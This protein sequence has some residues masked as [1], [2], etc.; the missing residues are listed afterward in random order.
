[1]VFRF[2]GKAYVV[3]TNQGSVKIVKKSKRT[4]LVKDMCTKIQTTTGICGKTDEVSNCAYSILS[5]RPSVSK[6]CLLTLNATVVSCSMQ[7]FYCFIFFI[8][9]FI[10][11]PDRIWENG[12]KTSGCQLSVPADFESF[13]KTYIDPLTPKD[14]ELRKLYQKANL[15]RYSKGNTKLDEDNKKLG[16]DMFKELKIRSAERMKELTSTLRR[17][18]SEQLRAVR[19]LEEEEKFNKC[20]KVYRLSVSRKLPINTVISFQL[21]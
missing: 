15:L 12:V 2:L 13:H 16:E 4:A 20:F 7:R 11:Q 8:V 10:V 14:H 1:A 6:L 3:D 21:Y 18:S 17:G 5:L 9:F 19:F